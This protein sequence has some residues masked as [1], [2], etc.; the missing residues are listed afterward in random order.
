MSLGWSDVHFPAASARNWG[1]M[2]PGEGSAQS[3][4][5]HVHC[6]TGHKLA[7]V[8]ILAPV[9]TLQA[10]LITAAGDRGLN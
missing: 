8:Q 4:P 6:S 10:S 1:E 3:F 2:P 9:I 5:G 7:T